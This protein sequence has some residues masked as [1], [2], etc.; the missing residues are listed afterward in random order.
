M[1]LAIICLQ[2]NVHATSSESYILRLNYGI[3]ARRI[4]KICLTEGFVYHHFHIRLPT[5]ETEVRMTIKPAENS[6]DEC[7]AVCL[8][9]TALHQSMVELATKN[10]PYG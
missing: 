4:D 10:Q 2:G 6:T 7:I 1:A 3:A 5:V 9:M 8:R